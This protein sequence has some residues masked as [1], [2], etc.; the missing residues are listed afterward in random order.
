ML[1]LKLV[2]ETSSKVVYDY[3]PEQKENFGTI[4]IDK[5]TGEVTDVKVS[6]NDLHERYMHHAVSRI[7]EFFKNGT[8][9]KE[10]I[11]AWY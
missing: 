2:E 10:D 9:N 5:I 8:Y 3:F 11:I 6:S 7:I 1:L 4:T